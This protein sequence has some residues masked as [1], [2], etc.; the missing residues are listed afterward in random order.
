MKKTLLLIAAAALAVFA[1]QPR[2]LAD[3]EPL[4]EFIVGESSLPGFTMVKNP[5]WYRPES[6]WNYINGGALPYLDYGVGDVVTWSGK[7]AP[8]DFEIVVDI[9]DM[10]GNRSAFGIYSSERFPEYDY[11]DIGVEGYRLDNAVC[12][13]KD[14]YYVKVVSN[15]PATPS[16]EPVERIAR[17]VGARI[18]DGDGMPSVFDLF[19]VK[20]R[21]PKSESFTAK[22][23]LG[24]DFLSNGFSVTY[25]IDGAEYAFHVLEA[26]NADMASEQ[27]GKYRDFIG[28]YGKLK[29]RK[30]N[31]GDDAFTGQESWYGLMVF[32]RKGRYI[33][34]SVGMSDYEDAVVNL[35]TILDGLR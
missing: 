26:D 29:R 24:Q 30:P 15:A 21:R 32:V 22:N 2:S 35:K 7:L 3:G 1:A 13:W 28:E 14:R 23:V 11:F 18:P 16:I 10:G 19:P 9:Y 17:A 25:D 4:G 8:H 5:E 34:G 31:I 33:A 20:N 6:L 27:F 12:F